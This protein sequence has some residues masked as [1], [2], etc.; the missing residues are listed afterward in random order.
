[1]AA[2]YHSLFTIQGLALLREA[3]QNGT[4]LGITHMAYGDGNGIVPTPN[5]DFTKLVNEVYRAPLNRLAPSKDNPNWLEADGVIPSA[6]GGF[7]IREVGL[8]AENVL[9]AYAN[10]PSTYK[11]SADQGTAQIKTIRI[12]LQIDNTANFEL[13]IDA[14]VVMATIQ[15]VE[16]ARNDAIKYADETK[17][18]HVESLEELLT[19]EVWDN[20]TVFLK[21]YW[22]MLNKGGGL[23]KYDSTKK[24]FNDGGTI[25]NGW[26]R[27]NIDYV[28]PE[29]FGAKAEDGYDDYN[30]LQACISHK[31]ETKLL[32]STYETSQGL[33]FKSGK[34]ITGTGISSVI[35]KTTSK[36]LSGVSIW[37]G[38]DTNYPN[39]IS[40][41]HNE[42][43]VLMSEV[44]D[45][46]YV[47]GVHLSGFKLRKEYQEGT[48]K[49]IGLYV[50]YFSES[51]VIDLFVENFE[52][53]VLGYSVWMVNWT[54]VQTWAKCGFSIGGKIG[55]SFL[56]KPIDGT[57][58]VFVACWSNYTEEGY[59]AWHL[60]AL[61]YSTLI[62]CG[63]EN[64][65]KLN[66][67]GGPA[68][69]VWLFDGDS[70]VSLVN[71][72]SENIHAYHLITAK[73]T[74]RGSRIS[75]KSILISGIYN[76]YNYTAESFSKPFAY[77]S[78]RTM[79][80]LTI[81]DS[82]FEFIYQP[83][84]AS[85][86]LNRFIDVADRSSLTYKKNNRLNIPISKIQNGGIAAS[87]PNQFIIFES[88]TS[89]LDVQTDKQSYFNSRMPAKAGLNS[90]NGLENL[91]DNI[92]ETYRQQ[93][94]RNSIQY[95]AAYLS[96]ENINNLRD[97]SIKTYVQDTFGNATLER[98]YPFNYGCFI[99]NYSA[100]QTGTQN[101]SVQIAYSFN[102]KVAFR[103]AD[104]G[105]GFTAWHSF[106]TTSNTTI[107]SDGTLKAAS[108]IIK[109]FSDH[110]ESNEEANEQNPEFT[111]IGTGHYCIKNTLGFAKEGW[112]INV[113]SD[114]NG[115]KIC[116]IK[117]QTLENGD[118]E[119]KTF[120]RKFD[121]ETASIVAD[122]S[123]PIDIPENMNG[124]QR[125]I[126][127]RL[128]QIISDE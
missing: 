116:A 6:V 93:I 21:S 67:V 53:G 70:I 127:I 123:Q 52:Y 8:Y 11:P 39:R 25:F 56:T 75:I 101:N 29:M 69:G 61:K 1:M 2:Q 107:T 83:D 42:D 79:A 20:R 99:Q 40:A 104:W 13:K 100:G 33:I 102:G 17:V 36:K 5:A 46:K 45:G 18:Q 37:G 111:K 110:L 63:A 58:N 47:R 35:K 81:E 16:E 117:Y 98:N 64:V 51:S 120:K 113:P 59:Y 34:K 54:R 112:W 19:I 94:I 105:K 57:S 126:D 32:C 49:G 80:A 22:P 41:D 71:C 89:V 95:N 103:A 88:E 74:I 85:A 119:V 92:D 7:N 72:G 68:D 15:S 90:L 60:N 4:K 108:P 48:R 3:I 43:V 109:L 62:S 86:S 91:Q 12:V 38:A 44:I 114:S 124:E 9:V 115:N 106:Y 73:G 125:W 10:Y 77:I 14:S 121:I 30:A 128:H 87:K 24:D 50:P 78:I 122:E 23:F 55:D 28:T 31:L 26:V 76:Q 66:G 65:G 118:I 27:L 96:T 97:S 82:F 84:S